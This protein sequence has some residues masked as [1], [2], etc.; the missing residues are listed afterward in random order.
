VRVLFIGD[1]YRTREELV[2]GESSSVIERRLLD[3]SPHR[4]VKVAHTTEGLEQRLRSPGWD[5]L[6]CPT[7]GPFFWGAGRLAQAGA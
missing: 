2:Y 6:V 7:S 3:G 5:I 1:S 4:T